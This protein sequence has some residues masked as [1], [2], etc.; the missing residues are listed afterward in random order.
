MT[1]KTY[2]KGSCNCGADTFSVSIALT[3]VFVCHCSICRKYSGSGGVAVTIVPKESIT[4]IS[5]ADLIQKWEK[6]N[7]GWLT[8]FCKVCGSPLLG[9]MM[10]NTPIF[11]LTC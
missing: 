5:G 11:P 8:N 10:S 7:H 4:F 2:A 9:K 1:S 3:D 6:P